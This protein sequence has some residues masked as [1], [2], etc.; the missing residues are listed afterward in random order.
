MTSEKHFNIAD[1]FEMVADAVPDR[2]ALVCAEQ[3]ATYRELD[4]RASQLA[5]FL[6]S[7]GV[8]PRTARRTLPLQLQRVSRGCP[9][10]LSSCAPCRST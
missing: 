2:I 3:R 6:R 1:L 5:H 7:R 4:A 8:R 10:L 9:R